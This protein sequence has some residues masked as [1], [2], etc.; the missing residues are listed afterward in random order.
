M[1]LFMKNYNFFKNINP[2]TFFLVFLIFLNSC[3]NNFFRGADARKVSPDPRERVKKNLQEGKG[4]RLDNAIKNRMTRGGNFEFAS[5]NEL[6]RA[7]LDIIEFMPLTSANYS[8]GI[9][10]TDWYTNNTNPNE[11]IKITIRFLSNE[12]RSD[13][14]DINVFYKKCDAE[15]KCIVQK[16]NKSIESEL[17]REILKKATLYQKQTKAKNKSFYPTPKTGGD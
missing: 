12:I 5:S 2:L 9:I 4:F 10:I 6:W 11:T 7:S 14:I 13:A 16:N 8:G 15:Y 3:G 17:R 1:S